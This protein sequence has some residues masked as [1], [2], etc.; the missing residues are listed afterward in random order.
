[1]TMGGVPYFSQWESRDLTAA[2]VA[3]GA[4]AALARDPLWAASGAATQAEYVEWAD[5]VCGMACLKMML[6]ARTGQV[7]PTLELARGC[8]EHGGYVRQPDGGI[9]GLIYAPFARYVAARFGMEAEVVVGVEAADLTGL[10]RRAQ[11]FMASVHP[12]IRWP[13][14][15]PPAQGGHLVLVHGAAAGRIVF[16]NPSGHDRAAQE[17]VALTPEVF[18]RF[19]AGR[20]VAVYAGGVGAA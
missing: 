9:K 14:R 20:G 16:H 1:M 12:G 3:E 7:V 13:E 4:K 8:A 17:D 5:H 2:V 10:L 6:A 19:F 18:G 11:F 15:A